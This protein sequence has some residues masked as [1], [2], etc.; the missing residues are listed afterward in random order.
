MRR[1]ILIGSGYGG[2]RTTQGTTGA[3]RGGTPDPGALGAPGQELPGPGVALQDRAGLWGGSDQQGG[4]R[5]AGHLASD[6]DQVARSVRAP[7][8]GGPVGRGPAAP[9]PPA[10]PRPRTA[11]A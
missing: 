11:R 7:A 9:P 4:R 2:A 5:A 1:I 3:N 8:A 6:G 10:P